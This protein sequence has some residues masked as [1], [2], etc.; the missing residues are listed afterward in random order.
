MTL[1]DLLMVANMAVVEMNLIHVSVTQDGEVCYAM[2]Q[3]V[4]KYNVIKAK[5]L[6]LRLRK[7]K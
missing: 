6:Y 3:F 4:S 2:N 5:Y 1:V 7:F